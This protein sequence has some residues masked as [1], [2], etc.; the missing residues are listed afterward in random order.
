MLPE[1][2]NAGVLSILNS[3]TPENSVERFCRSLSHCLA[4]VPEEWQERVWAAILTLIAA[5]QGEQELNHVLGPI[6]QW[7]AGQL[8]I[9]MASDTSIR[10]VPNVGTLSSRAEPITAT[11]QAESMA[12][13]IPLPA[14][15]SSRQHYGPMSSPYSGPPAPS[16]SLHYGQMSGPYS[17]PPAPSSSQHYGQMSGPYSGPPAP[18]SSQYYGQMSDPYSGPPASSQHYGQMS[19]PY[20]GPPAPTSSQCY[21]QMAGHASGSLVPAS[22]HSSQKKSRSFLVPPSHASRHHYV[23]GSAPT[24]TYSQQSQNVPSI[25]SVGDDFAHPQPYTLPARQQTPVFEHFVTH[26]HL[27]RG[28]NTTSQSYPSQISESESTS[29]HPQHVQSSFLG[30]SLE[31]QPYP[32]P[33]SVSSTMFTSTP[34]Q[35]PTLQGQLSQG[36]M[37]THSASPEHE[38]T[39]NPS[40]ESF[41]SQSD[42]VDL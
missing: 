30:V 24:S 32:P 42:L 36:Q 16:S 8:P 12:A 13:S 38:S 22:R 41:S 17:G 26:S 31:P 34:H 40:D 5:C 19:G 37:G 25:I 23:Q 3:L 39:L 1:L 7:R 27:T 21:G 4:K 35:T 11:Q 20:S 9:Q 18:S 2:I 6:E 33:P 15:P 14:A 28:E 29:A 10:D